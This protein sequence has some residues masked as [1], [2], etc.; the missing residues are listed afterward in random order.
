MKQFSAEKIQEVLNFYTDEAPGSYIKR[1][2]MKHLKAEETKEKIFNIESQ[3]IDSGVEAR[4]LATMLELAKEAGY[5]EVHDHWGHRA[6]DTLTIDEAI[7]KFIGFQ[8]G[9]PTGDPGVP[10]PPGINYLSTD[11]LGDKLFTE[12]NKAYSQTKPGQIYPRW[13]EEDQLQWIKKVF[14]Q[15]TLTAEDKKHLEWIYGRL[16]VHGENE[17]ADFMLKFKDIINNK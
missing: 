12:Y 2:F 9:D 13:F 3:S 6:W 7:A 10:G 14:D 5:T 1:D 17:N 15:N 16:I 8:S 4:M 11:P